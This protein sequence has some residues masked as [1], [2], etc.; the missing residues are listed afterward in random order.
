MIHVAFALFA[1]LAVA[2]PPHTPTG[3]VDLLWAQKIPMRDGV[4]LNATLFLPHNRSERVPVIVTLTPYIADT[5]HAR[6]MFFA[7]HGFAFALVDARG[8][9]SSQ[10]RFDPLHQE[11]KDG[12]DVVE[13]L[14]RQPWSSG[15]VAMWGGSYAGFDQWMTARERPA[16]LAT[17]VPAASVYAGIDY[18]IQNGVTWPYVLRWLT[19]TSGATGNGNLFNHD[20]FWRQKALA[21]LRGR[22]AYRDFDDIVGNTNTAFETW[23]KHPDY[24]AYWQ[25]LAVAPSQYRAMQL[26]ILTITGAYDDDQ[27]GAL[28]YY[29]QHM[30]HGDPRV[31][32]QHFLIVGPWDHA[33]TRTPA[34]QFAGL[35]VG[36]AAVLDLNEL[37][38]Q[39]YAFTMTGAPRPDFLRDRVAYYVLGA[40]EWRYAR[41]LQEATASTHTLYLDSDGT[42]RSVFASGRLT[43]DK[44]R[45]GARDSWV[46][47]PLD[48]RG[49]E[50]DDE[51]IESEATDQRYA[52]Q[53]DG[54][55]VVYHSSALSGPLE[56]CG[57]LRLEVWMSMD[58]ADT[59]FLVQVSEIRRDGRAVALGQDVLRARYRVSTST[60]TPVRPG[61]LDRYVFDD[62]NWMGRRIEKGSR[63]RL[64]IRPANTI[65][66]QRNHNSG[67]VV[68]QETSAVARVAHIT[69]VHDEAHPSALQLPLCEAPKR[70]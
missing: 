68:A 57:A 48:L 39:W 40:E 35:E 13:W 17:I 4:Q 8:R 31:T 41:T 46:Y 64:V 58:V 11:P 37:H 22:R 66:Y 50:V 24:D 10:G 65:H 69:L 55:G 32:A 53:I 15:K 51:K 61:S 27:L 42:A 34:R 25:R 38:R 52:L 70:P 49:L 7:Q 45:T 21:L 16:H 56:I 26:P 47:D 23:L 14:A 6:A 1:G 19:Y 20:D 54:D 36:E 59:D 33:G 30:E 62:F 2:R 67:G 29:R 43:V 28:T 12:H 18:P 63:F 3:D 60:P 9:G 5:Y 44:P